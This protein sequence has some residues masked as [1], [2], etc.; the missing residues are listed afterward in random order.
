MVQQQVKGRVWLCHS[1]Q[2][3]EL[4]RRYGEVGLESSHLCLLQEQQPLD[5]EGRFIQRR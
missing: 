2:A 3:S 4:S 1:P 5:Q